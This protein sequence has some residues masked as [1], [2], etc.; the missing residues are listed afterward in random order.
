MYYTIKALPLTL[1]QMY[2]GQASPANDANA[3][4]CIIYLL[5]KK[6]TYSLKPQDT[7]VSHPPKVRGNAYCPLHRHIWLV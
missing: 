1:G 3:I 2:C 7:T 6:V 5:T 4:R